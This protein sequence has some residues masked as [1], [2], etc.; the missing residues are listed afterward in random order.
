M[1]DPTPQPPYTWS[2][3]QN[4]EGT[5]AK[6]VRESLIQYNITRARIDES[7]EIAVIVR[8]I[9]QRLV[10]GATGW[11]W[12]SCMEISFLWVHEGLRGQGYGTR[13]MQTIEREARARGCG[14][15]VLDTFT[16]QAPSF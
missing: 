6:E 4:P 16:F 13:L 15:L 11:L 8:D 3:L 12:G 2:V 14:V 5:A 10:A 7:E 9:Y 1:S